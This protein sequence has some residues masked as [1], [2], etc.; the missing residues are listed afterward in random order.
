[1]AIHFT[2]L[3]RNFSNFFYHQKPSYDL[4]GKPS[5]EKTDIIFRRKTWRES[6]VHFSYLTHQLV[7][8]IIF[9]LLMTTS[10]KLLIFY[11]E[12]T[13]NFCTLI[14][15]L[16]KNLPLFTMAGFDVT[17]HSSSLLG[18]RRRLGDYTYHTTTPPDNRRNFFSIGAYRC[19]NDP[20]M[21]PCYPGDMVSVSAFETDDR[22]FEPRQ[23]ARCLINFVHCIQCCFCDLTFIAVMNLSKINVETSPLNCLEA[24]EGTR[25]DNSSTDICTRYCWA[26]LSNLLT[27]SKTEISDPD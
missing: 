26:N 5:F 23:C 10:S 19:H 25:Y 22:G 24:F 12:E 16:S 13:F 11:L 8:A 4:K 21:Y 17:T 3:K 27:Y 18:D 9:Y 20:T 2:S 14:F 15:F 7:R 1:L 6:L